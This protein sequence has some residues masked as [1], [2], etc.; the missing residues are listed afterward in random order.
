MD[1]IETVRDLPSRRR[2]AGWRDS[3]MIRVMGWHGR[4][5]P[6]SFIEFGWCDPE[7][8]RDVVRRTTSS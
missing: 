1:L 6:G 2:W 5:M 8:S 7:R 4:R 3:G